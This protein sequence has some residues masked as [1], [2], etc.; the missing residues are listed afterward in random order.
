MGDVHD[1]FPPSN[2]S[3]AAS[4][5]ATTGHSPIDSAESPSD[6]LKEKSIPLD[7]LKRIN[8]LQFRGKTVRKKPKSTKAAIKKINK[9]YFDQPVLLGEGAY[10]MVIQASSVIKHNGEL[11]ERPKAFKIVQLPKNRKNSRELKKHIWNEY[12]RAKKIKYLGLRR[13]VKIG[14][15]RILP[16]N[17]LPGRDLSDIIDDNDSG[18]EKLDIETLIN[19]TRE[20]FLAYREIIYKNNLIH[21]DLKPENIRY[22]KTEGKIY[23]FDFAFAEKINECDNKIL[24]TPE[25]LDPDTVYK[26][27][28]G[29]PKHSTDSDTHALGKILLL[30]WNRQLNVDVVNYF[31]EL[32]EEINKQ[33]HPEPSLIYNWSKKLENES[34]N[35]KMKEQ[36]SQF[37]FILD[38][39]RNLIQ[40]EPDKRCSLDEAI[41][42]LEMNFK[43][44]EIEQAERVAAKQVRATPPLVCQ[45][46]VVGK[47]S[48]LGQLGMFADQYRFHSKTNSGYS[49]HRRLTL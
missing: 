12:N 11:A 37:N 43:Q 46:Q 49:Q 34:L 3:A 27:I 47:S 29:V 10:A 15:L 7:I 32:R 31:N 22:D 18:D 28:P 19:I 25:F 42:F 40:C 14:N 6:N 41:E 20:L 16:M 8:P 9:A 13:R 5:S 35:F 44:A 17:V 4:S 33:K 26:K 1:K 45:G 36:Y 24:G 21:R 23:F 2:S 38:L 39:V 30:V 48:A